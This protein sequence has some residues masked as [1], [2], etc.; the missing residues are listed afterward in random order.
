MKTNVPKLL[1]GLALLGAAAP[2]AKASFVLYSF[3]AGLTNI[4]DA[5]GLSRTGAAGIAALTDS[6]TTTGVAN[7]GLNGGSL[8]G[9]FGGG[10]YFN[11]SGA[12][13]VLVGAG[14]GVPA[15]GTFT[16]SLRLSDNSYTPGISFSDTNVLAA[17]TSDTMTLG[18]EDP[19]SPILFTMAA[20]Y[21]YLPLEISSFS[22][23]GL[24]V[25][26]IKLDALSASFPDL[27]YIGVVAPVPE[28]SSMAYLGLTTLGG[29]TTMRRRRK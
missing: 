2:H 1:C 20:D 9:D 13:I 28:P 12:D 26:G 11:I 7:V 27:N 22:T 16:V 8:A 5:S 21:F 25:T 3:Q 19:A 14:G 4:T 24:G 15:W 29:L 23:G 6:S 17:G 18:Q 10:A